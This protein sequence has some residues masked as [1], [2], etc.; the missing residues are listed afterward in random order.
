MDQ[1]G[2]TL[3]EVLIV[4]ALLLA[5]LAVTLPRYNAVRYQNS[6]QADLATVM[7]LE[8]TEKTYKDLTGVHSFDP[9]EIQT[10][11]TFTSSMMILSEMV[12]FTGFEVLTQPRWIEVEGVWCIEAQEGEGYVFSS[13][14]S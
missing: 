7:L 9:L 5:I 11:E 8:Q 1:K 14:Q 13:P 4:M 3:L 6:L 10:V 12:T 2:F